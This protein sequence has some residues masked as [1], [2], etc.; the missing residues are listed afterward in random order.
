MRIIAAVPLLAIALLLVSGCGSSS[1]P[2]A[3]GRNDAGNQDAKDG[4]GSNLAA[5]F[6]AARAIT[7]FSEKD[8]AL[9]KVAEDAAQAGDVDTVQKCLGEITVFQLR[10]DTAYKAALTLAKAGKTDAGT[11]VEKS[12]SV[13]S[14]RDEALGKIAKGEFGK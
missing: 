14:R 10:D 12:I 4:Q 8:A 6:K 7:I 9:A 2:D 11:E 5:R 1:H 13:F 3:K